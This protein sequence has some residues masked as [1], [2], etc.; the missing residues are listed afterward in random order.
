MAVYVVNNDVDLGI[1]QSADPGAT[2]IDLRTGASAPAG[3]IWV[4]AAGMSAPQGATKL[5]GA[6]RGATKT[7]VTSYVASGAGQTSATDLSA[8]GIIQ[9]T[10]DSY[11]LGSLAD[12]AWQQYL[13]SGSVDYVW[14]LLPQQ[15][16]FQA[17]FPAYNQLAQEGRGIS[18]AEYNS[19]INQMVN[20]GKQYGVPDG[21]MDPE[22]IG[23]MLLGGKDAQE[24]EEDLQDY[25]V[26]LAHPDVQARLIAQ[27][28]DPSHLTPGG[29]AAFFTDPK[30]A[31]PL[32]ERQF[33][34][35]QLGAS[36]D[37]F[38]VSI[39][40]DEANR[41]ALAGVSS[42]AGQSAFGQVGAAKPLLAALPGSSESNISNDQ[43]AEALVGGNPEAAA[44]LQARQAR[45]LAPFQA[46][47]AFTTS[48]AGGGQGVAAG[49]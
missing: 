5:E 23:N 2:I 15:P 49:A 24:V 3:A 26:A 41:L 39:S 44:N 33:T 36:S 18:I 16:A 13:N 46:G 19:Y 14:A 31:Q 47:G 12:W 8:K 28:L 45:R 11:G 17:R 4:G 40:N 32:L 9:Q 30:K 38:G 29:L 37:R 1:V 43:A 20:L 22:T 6:D 34:A 7:M 27:G 25:A 48:A 35:A 21:F 42:A 10:L